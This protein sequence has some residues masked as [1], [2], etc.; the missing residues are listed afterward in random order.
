[1]MTIAIAFFL[2]VR[3]YKDEKKGHSNYHHLIFTIDL[4]LFLILI[5][6]CPLILLKLKRIFKNSNKLSKK[7]HYPLFLFQSLLN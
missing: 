5:K 2:F 6:M 1:V 7:L 3:S 4:N